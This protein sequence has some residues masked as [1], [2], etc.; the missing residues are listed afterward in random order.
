MKIW[1]I[2][3]LQFC[4][5]AGA[6]TAHAGS[7]AHGGDAVVCFSIPMSDAMGRDGMVTA[8]GRRNI[9]KAVT[10]EWYRASLAM[11]NSKIKSMI[12]LPYEKALAALHSQFSMAPRF[13]KSLDSAH[14]ILGN[15]SERALPATA[16]LSDIRDSLTFVGYPHNCTLVQAAVREEDLITYD[17]DVWNAMSGFQ[18]A[19][20]Q[21][22]EELYYLGSSR[23]DI[24]KHDDSSR[25]QL[26]ILMLLTTE[27]LTE[28]QMVQGLNRYQFGLYQ[29]R[30]ELKQALDMFRSIYS[31]IDPL[32]QTIAAHLNP[33][34]E[35]G[36]T[37]YARLQETLRAVDYQS[38]VFRPTL[39][40][41]ALSPLD[42][43]ISELAPNG[44][45]LGGMLAFHFNWES[46]VTS[47]WGQGFLQ[48]AQRIHE[49]RLELDQ[50]DYGE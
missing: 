32:C 48:T 21:L 28:Q 47:A 7:E 18:Q 13:R 25:T 38:R 50:I 22:H 23:A 30:S 31:H 46:F 35:R 24:Y 6:S 9:S 37:A 26:L 8:A 19:L 11:R 15:I 33:E 42:S 17:L 10:L 4:V 41:A 14:E 39:P 12:N 44:S 36:K 5:A 3:A 43:Y 49:Q 1:K 27:N 29:T 16:G 2:L 20:L 40:Y 45:D 34:S